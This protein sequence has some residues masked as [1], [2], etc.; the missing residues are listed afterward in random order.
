LGVNPKIRE[1]RSW[2]AVGAA[3]AIGKQY[4]LRTVDAEAPWHQRR[5]GSAFHKWGKQHGFG[6]MRA[7]D[8]SYAIEL[9]ENLKAITASQA[10]LLERE[11]RRLIGAITYKIFRTNR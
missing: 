10:T 9:H 7:S 2:A 6:S 3:L 5:Y 11:R 4:A 1:L 8:R